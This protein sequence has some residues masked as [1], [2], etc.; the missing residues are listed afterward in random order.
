MS[1]LVVGSVAYDAVKTPFGQADEVLGG[2]ATHFSVSAS[3]FAEVAIVACVGEDFRREDEEFL[4]SRD[5]D[6]LGLEHLDGK[7]FRWAGEYGYD[8]NEAKTLDT[9]LNVFADFSPKIPALYRDK[10]YIFLGNIDPKL[11]RSVLAQVKSPR[12]VAC[13]T[14]NYWIEGHFKSLLETLR[15]VDAL[16]INDAETRQLAGESNLVKAARK[17]LSW[18]PTTLVVKRGE[19]GVLMFRKAEGGEMTVFGAPAYPL[20][21]VF[22]PTGAGDTFAGGF[23]GYLA[24][25]GRNDPE[26]MRQAIVFG[27]IMA[28]FNVEKFSLDRL[29]ELTFTEIRMRYRELRE[30]TRFEDLQEVLSV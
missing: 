21:D 27:S 9:Q 26:A 18:G 4:R 20:E 16:L 23:M 15:Q 10:Q 14:M 5:I 29:R 12:L 1:I 17:I 7:T 28:S 3:F 11:Q 30:M 6:L 19:Y 13:D 24:G 2:A 8:L 22:D 25:S